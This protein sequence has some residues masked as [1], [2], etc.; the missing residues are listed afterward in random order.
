[1]PHPLPRL[2]VYRELF[3]CIGDVF[4]QGDSP[5]ASTIEFFW[6]QN[7]EQLVLRTLEHNLRKAYAKHRAS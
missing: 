6:E 5:T 3:V 1:M 2:Q 7:V 4:E